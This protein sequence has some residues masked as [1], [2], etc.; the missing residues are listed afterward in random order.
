MIAKSVPA[1]GGT[2]T[3]ANGIAYISKHEHKQQRELVHAG[4]SFG[5]RVSYA[6]APEKAAW[7]H[8]RGV[9]SLATAALEMEAVSQR[10]TR[11]ADPVQHEI[12]AYAKHERPSPEQIVADAQRLLAALDMENHQYVLSVHTDTDDLH[13]HIIANRIGPDGRAN[14]RWQDR[15]ARERVCAQ[16]AAERG[17]DIVVGFHNRDIVQEHLKL[18][19]LPPPPAR[20]I[21][22]ADFNRVHGRGELP[23]QD[24]ARPYVLDAVQRAISWDDLRERLAG[25][26]VVLKAVERGGRFQGLA[27]AESMERDAPGCSASRIAEAC[28]RSRLEARW[29]P[30]VPAGHEAARTVLA[31]E[32]GEGLWRDRM[33]PHIL[34]AV[35]AAA[36]W[37]DLK[38]RLEAHGVVLKGI[39]RGGRFQGLAFAQGSAEDAPGCGASRIG[40]RCKYR[41]LEARFGLFPDAPQRVRMETDT[42]PPQA[43]ERAPEKA[44]PEE[45][46]EPIRERLERDVER[47]AQWAVARAHSIADNARLRADY[48]QY[49]EHFFAARR[50]QGAERRE[51][52]WS[53]ELAQRRVESERRWE[54]KRMQGAVLRVV[55]P[56]GGLRRMG[57]AL[58]DHFHERRTQ[59]ERAHARERWENVKAE[60]AQERGREAARAPLCY[61]DFVVEKAQA[62]DEGA[63]RMREH[64]EKQIRNERPAQPER[65]RTV[66]E[67][68]CS[69]SKLR[70][71]LLAELRTQAFQARIRRSFMPDFLELRQ[72]HQILEARLNLLDSR[73][74]TEIAV[75]RNTSGSF[76]GHIDK[77]EHAVERAERLSEASALPESIS[78]RIEPE[79]IASREGYE[80]LRAELEE[81]ERQLAAQAATLEEARKRLPFVAVPKSPEELQREAWAS[82]VQDAK[83]V[84]KPTEHEVYRL[85]EAWKQRESWNPF[86][87]HAG[88]KTI[89]EIA[90]AGKE[91][92]EKAMAQARTIHA[93]HDIPAITARFAIQTK[94]RAA[95]EER[96]AT[97]RE[98]LRTVKE[99]RA[100]IGAAQADLKSLKRAGIP[101]ET[102]VRVLGAYE[103]GNARV[104]CAQ[105]G[106]AK[107]ELVREVSAAE[108]RRELEP[109]AQGQVRD[110]GEEERKAALAMLAQLKDLGAKARLCVA[111][112]TR[113]LVQQPQRVQ[114]QAREIESAQTREYA[115][116]MSRGR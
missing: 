51:A 71:E 86:A 67:V 47:S 44:A 100:E 37:D 107:T 92:E 7:T 1:R 111:R 114:E 33:R 59:S 101:E 63:R 52:A 95:W 38:T 96:S 35:D 97:I 53:A 56:R 82:L 89:R 60:L 32:V 113:Q 55:T 28:K 46:Q 98:Q 84:A 99:E 90:D 106:L 8:T 72:R 50:E 26:G 43:V 79:T 78:G 2:R 54:A 27:F 6:S 108:L 16:I 69:T 94:Q 87:R 57:Y 73:G 30:Y 102:L 112:E 24:A 11:C 74:V 62:G 23:W 5:D 80:R 105:I 85:Q 22:D 10:S 49:R 45:V 66:E 77:I 109:I 17:W 20:R 61:R 88:E 29:G 34:E 25:H 64:L 41:A 31:T 103:P 93:G 48:Q 15:P 83:E 21:V 91:R 68:Q 81:L 115:R 14:I 70:E 104:L 18:D 65:V 39:E 116:G 19:A 4:A 75:E 110:F 58:I 3:F 13:A 36:S 42:Q 9:S 76:E 12:I 40:E